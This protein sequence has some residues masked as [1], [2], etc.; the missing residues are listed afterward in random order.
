MFTA[1]GLERTTSIFTVAETAQC[2]TL[3]DALLKVPTSPKM[4]EFKVDRAGSAPPK[5]KKASAL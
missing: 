4:N 1:A 5:N 2:V 3:I